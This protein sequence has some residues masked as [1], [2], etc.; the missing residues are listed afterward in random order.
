MR[1]TILCFIVALTSAMAV[2]Q[3]PPERFQDAT[4]TKTASVDELKNVDRKID[5]AFEKGDVSLIQH[6]LAEEMINVLPEGNI[7]K[8]ADFL[9]AVKP[10]KAGTTLTITE[11][12]VEVF[13]FGDTGIVTS[14]KTARW[15]RSNGSSSDAYRETNTYVRKD[16][17]W[18]LLASQTSHAPPP[19]SA[20]DVNLN[21]PVDETQLGGNRNA[22]VVLVEFADY[23][24]PYCRDF[25]SNTMKQIERDYIDSGRIGF[26]FHDFPIE[27]SH[28]HA[29]SAALAALCAAE[30]GHLWEMN[31]KLLAESSALERDV[32]F[33]D[34]E[35]LRLDMPKFA[36]CFADEKSATRLRQSMR[37]ASQAGIDGTPMFVLGIRKP[38]STTIKGL[39]M[40]EG[41]YPYEVFK[42]TLDMLIATQN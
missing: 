24:C 33:R 1:A 28:P 37:E 20:K 27:S 25:A 21:L 7:S 32:L 40:I 35:T 17:Q 13:V 9:Q 18:F 8:K 22:S 39:R 23:E 30:Q 31:H 19:Y 5:V 41:D 34:A 16:G 14:N 6:L 2:A 42:A 4:P 11:K 38:G 10:P 36:G 15:Q 12:E 3:K 26:L 29:F